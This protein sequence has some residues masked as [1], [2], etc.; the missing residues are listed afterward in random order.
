MGRQEQKESVFLCCVQSALK[1]SFCTDQVN[2][3]NIIQAVI[4]SNL[5]TTGA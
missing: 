1:I 4:T 2:P 3:L 5:A